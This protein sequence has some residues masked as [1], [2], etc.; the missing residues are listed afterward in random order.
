MSKESRIKK[1]LLNA[2]IN[3]ICY[4]VSLV[5]AFFSRK[6]FIDQLGVEFIGLTGTLSSLLSFLNL[7][8][9]GVGSAIGYVL[10]KPIYE[11]DKIKINE[12]ISIFG[13]LY[14]CIGLYILGAGVILSFFLP[15]I[16]PNTSFTW[17]II[18][19]GY[20]AYLASS[21]FGY[22]INYRQTLLSADQR[23]YEV[24]SYYQVVT[25]TKIILQMLL[26][27]YIRSFAL[28]LINEL[29]FG[30]IYTLILNWRI[31]KV[32]PWLASDLKLGRKLFK[33][34]PEIGKYVKQ[35]FIHKVT[36]FVQYQLTPFLI[37]SYVSLPIV[38]LYGN[39]TLITQKLQGLI[40]G[41]LDSTSAGVGNLI[42]EG[43][44]EK[45]VKIY[46]ELFAVRMLIAGISATCIAVLSSPFIS[47]W[48]GEEYPLQSL[49]VN[50]IALQLF[51]YML[52]GT[53][54][55][56]IYGYGLF[57]DVWAPVAES[58]LFIATSM[59]FGSLW[60]L[61]GVLCG[62]L[63]SMLIIIYIWKPYFLFSKGFKLPFYKYWQVF[64]IHITPIV[65]SYILSIRIYDLLLKKDFP[66]ASWMN[67]LFS[68]FLFFTIMSFCSIVSMYIVSKGMRDFIHRFTKRK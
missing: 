34:Y 9:L 10:Y 49:I 45:I 38:A 22:F 3:L 67:W 52:R 11:D 32:Y 41:I 62:P 46:Q 12:I 50:V 61:P 20:Y 47:I 57:Y 16:F 51:M 56:F 19:I 18:Y 44:I 29:I 5:I 31:D 1:S 37:Y 6:I 39:Y 65:V 43:N 60:G 30:F 28:Y 33:K 25:S 64:F 54:D 2:R 42:S 58:A 24:T 13:Y 21:L 63:L 36:T 53:T 4:L 27:L 26:A 48:L 35:L 17:L 40:S 8:E 68:A 55:A 59:V 14:R 23:N 66:M 7:A 15:W